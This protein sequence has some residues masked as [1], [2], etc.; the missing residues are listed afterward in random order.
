MRYHWNFNAAEFR[1]TEKGLV[2]NLHSDSARC[3]SDKEEKQTQRAVATV[4][5]FPSIE[6]MFAFQKMI[7]DNKDKVPVKTGDESYM[8][9]FQAEVG[10]TIILPSIIIYQHAGAKCDCKGH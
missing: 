5:F 3:Q 4:T 6:Q 9:D 8:Y 7:T 10:K 1:T 2:H